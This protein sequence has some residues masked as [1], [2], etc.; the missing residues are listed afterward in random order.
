[1]R[2]DSLLDCGELIY[3]A[4]VVKIVTPEGTAFLIINEDP[5]SGQPVGFDLQFGKSGMTIRAWAFALSRTMTLAVS[6]GA[7]IE[8]LIQELSNITSDQ[9]N[10]NG[11]RSGVDGVVRG[12]I[13]YQSDSFVTLTGYL[14][15]VPSFGGD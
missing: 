12:L 4:V 3:N 9:I 7:S 11:I 1:M 15:N 10:S 8:D 13:R 2:R 14:D 6:H 5:D